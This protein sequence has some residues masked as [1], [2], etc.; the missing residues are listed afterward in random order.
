MR[1]KNDGYEMQA[2]V[3]LFDAA[4]SYGWKC[5]ADLELGIWPSRFRDNAGY[6]EY[7]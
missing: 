5:G 2:S 1:D 6:L 3:E 7:G 4:L